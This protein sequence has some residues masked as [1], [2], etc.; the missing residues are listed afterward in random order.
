VGPD[1][2]AGVALLTQAASTVSDL[3]GEVAKVVDR[4][5]L[6]RVPIL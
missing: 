5:R 6:E 1:Q 2:D 3:S 4:I